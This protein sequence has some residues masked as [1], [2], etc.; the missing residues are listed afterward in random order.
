MAATPLRDSDDNIEGTDRPALKFQG[1]YE[2]PGVRREGPSFN[3]LQ[4]R[5]VTLSRVVPD[6]QAVEAW[7]PSTA[8]RNGP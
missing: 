6:D 4:A 8:D 7:G 3:R 1:A 5:L 2:T